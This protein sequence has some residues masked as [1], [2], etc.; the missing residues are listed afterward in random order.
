M[1]STTKKHMVTAQ[2]CSAI[3]YDLTEEEVPNA[4][5]IYV[6][7]EGEPLL[8]AAGNLTFD[9]RLY[10]PLGKDITGLGI[11]K[12][13]L[14]V[15]KF[16]VTPAQ[17]KACFLEI[18]EDA[19]TVDLDALY[20][21]NFGAPEF[22]DKGN[23]KIK[24]CGKES[25]EERL[26]APDG[27]D[28]VAGSK[29]TVIPSAK[30]KEFV[31][32]A[33]QGKALGLTPRQAK[34]TGGVVDYHAA[35]Q[36]YIETR[37]SEFDADGNLH[38]EGKI[39]APDGKEVVAKKPAKDKK[40]AA[41]KGTPEQQK[42][43]GQEL[44][45]LLRNYCKRIVGLNPVEEHTNVRPEVRVSLLTEMLIQA[46][47]LLAGDQPEIFK[48][49]DRALASHTTETPSKKF[50]FPLSIKI[51]IEP[52]A[53]DYDIKSQASFSTKHVCNIQGSVRTGPDLF[54]GE[55]EDNTFDDTRMDLTI[56]GKPPVTTTIGALKKVAEIIKQRHPEE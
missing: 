27:R 40:K 17:A 19:L 11:P 47:T 18:P 4:H 51:R 20:T 39:Y 50:S 5:K 52:I 8:D 33:A 24:F 28:L 35:F 23:L 32:T 21:E 10:S 14:P 56:P 53:H 55:C 34:R 42:K 22:D 9:G 30:K 7:S 1:K 36:E 13:T 29:L 31:V 26:L 48:A 12:Q 45:E 49:Y 43:V 41:A 25:V 46:V 38:H 15:K 16:Q 37:E 44:T 6:Q 2:Q 3:G 54:E